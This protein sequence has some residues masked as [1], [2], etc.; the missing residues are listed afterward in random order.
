MAL[1]VCQHGHLRRVCEVC[2][3]AAEIS[4]LTRENERLKLIASL[5]KPISVDRYPNLDAVMAGCVS[6]SPSEWPRI[7]RE[8][9]DLTRELAELEK[10]V[11]ALM[12]MTAK[13]CDQAH[14]VEATQGW[15]Y[16]TALYD[17]MKKALA[18]KE[19]SDGKCKF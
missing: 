8:I 13:A 17:D 1:Q 2:E 19:A 5:A 7:R 4:R 9:Q 14:D 11:E 12:S 10:V 3:K 16:L 18:T 6:G 15:H